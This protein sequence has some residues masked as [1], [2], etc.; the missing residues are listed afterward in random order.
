MKELH[1][2]T[3]ENVPLIINNLTKAQEFNSRITI[4][5]SAKQMKILKFVINNQWV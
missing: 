5:F 3:D 1:E 2:G 4:T